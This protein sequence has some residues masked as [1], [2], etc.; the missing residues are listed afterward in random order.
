MTLAALR[1]IKFALQ[2]FWRNFWLSIATISVLVLALFSVNILVGLQATS[3][4]IIDTVED[5]VDI[6]FMINNSAMDAEVNNFQVFLKNM[7]MVEAVNFLTREEVLADF[8]DKNRDNPTITEALEQLDEN[9]FSSTIIVKA[10]DNADYEK[11]LSA[12]RTSEYDKLVENKDFSDPE[13]VIAAVRG[14][15]E[16][17]EYCGLALAIIFSF[18]AFLI[19]FNTIRVAIYT[20]KE[21]IAVMRL[22]GATN[23]FIRTPY[24]IESIIY[25]IL[26][27]AI[28]SGLVFLL[29]RV[30]EPGFMS[31]LGSYNLSL[32][33]FFRDNFLMIFGLEFVGTILLTMVSSAIAVKKYLKV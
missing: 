9:P 27:T 28:T 4:A 7:D 29:L 33:D 15:S 8:Q 30:A 25:A 18:I 16:K 21:E 1:I 12:V 6:N 24:L 2:D 17:I 3:R 31:F 26:A 32:T 23:R 20:H 19:V 10:K 11:I 22:V 5:K 14:V 13:K